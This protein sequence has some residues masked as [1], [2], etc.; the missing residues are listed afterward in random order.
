MAE[1]RQNRRPAYEVGYGKPPAATR[2]KPGQS[3][4]PRGRRKG[5]KNLRTI[6]ENELMET[7]TVRID[8][9][10][11]K[12]TKMEA[13]SKRMVGD[14]LQGNQKAMAKVMDLGQQLDIGGCADD[15]RMPTRPEDEEIIGRFVEKQQGGLNA[16]CS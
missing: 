14:A 13:I 11:R 10:A 4:N 1:E 6:I 7:V 15:P 3:G 16:A 9:K 2:F 12:L 8:G 5:R